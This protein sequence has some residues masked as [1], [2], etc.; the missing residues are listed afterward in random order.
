[1]YYDP[2]L[3]RL[4]A[5][6]LTDY[7]ARRIPELDGQVP[8]V[9]FYVEYNYYAISI[10][11]QLDFQRMPESYDGPAGLRWR[12]SEWS[13]PADAFLTEETEAALEPV[14]RLLMSSDPVPENL[15]CALSHQFEELAFRSLEQATPLSML[16]PTS[17]AW[18]QLADVDDI[19]ERMSSMLR[20]NPVDRLRRT[21]PEWR[22]LA[23]LLPAARADAD[24][25]RETRDRLDR[26]P[27]D[28]DQPAPDELSAVLR[29]CGLGLDLVVTEDHDAVYQALN[30]ANRLS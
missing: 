11:T 6:D 17:I 12:S 29:S 28:L 8:A 1:M 21:F 13:F 18:V 3:A 14:L 24:L 16:P 2:Q 4:V 10:A 30:L 15:I 20:T 25:V 7:L 9:S 5:R 27:E 26:S 19:Y 22:R 23:E